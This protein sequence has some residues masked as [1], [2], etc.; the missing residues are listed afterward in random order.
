MKH[1]YGKPVQS[2]L[3][4]K[5]QKEYTDPQI[6]PHLR[7]LMIGQNKASE[8]YI[9]QKREVIENLGG[10]VSVTHF[11]ETDDEMD[12]L[13]TIETYN[14]DPKTDGILLQLP[15]PQSHS[16]F[17]FLDTISADKDVDG[18]TAGNLGALFYDEQHSELKPATAKAVLHLL[19]HYNINL[20]GQHVVLV[21]AGLLVNQPLY[22]LCIS[23]GASVTTVHKDTPEI[24]PYTRQGD[25]VISATGRPGLLTA[26]HIKDGATVIDVGFSRDSTGQIVGDV[27]AKDVKSKAS[28]ISPVPGGVGPVTVACLTENLFRATELNL[29]FE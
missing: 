23:R 18:L 5:I 9:A 27:D 7:I 2:S 20:Q 11:S 28:A 1:L 22:H 10:K 16:P 26:D 4:H 19:T 25:I 24:Q 14:T 17:I 6:T 8:T 3:L 15:V 29:A 13:D 12:I 21:G